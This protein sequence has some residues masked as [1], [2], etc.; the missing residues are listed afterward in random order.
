MDRT[1]MGKGGVATGRGWA[2]GV[3]SVWMHWNGS[4]IRELGDLG[5][6]RV[7][8]HK[9]QCGKALAAPCGQKAQK[10]NDSSKNA[11]LSEKTSILRM[12]GHLGPKWPNF[13]TRGVDFRTKGVNFRTRGVNFRTRGPNFRTRGRIS[14][15][16]GSISARRGPISARGGTISAR[17]CPGARWGLQALARM[18]RRSK[19]MNVE[20]FI[21][22]K[23]FSGYLSNTK[24]FGISDDN[25][26][27]RLMMR[28]SGRLGFVGWLRWTIR[29]ISDN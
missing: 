5:Q 12:K 29:T 16:G 1:W 18:H 13:R 28:R 14:A 24:L 4:I 9:E 20:S 3:D 7:D 8:F 27:I 6:I 23:F 15:R 11:Y 19:S 2:M 26:V 17:G 25:C 22:F 21:V 10:T